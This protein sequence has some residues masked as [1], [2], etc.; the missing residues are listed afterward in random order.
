MGRRAGG[1]VESTAS[2]TAGSVTTALADLDAQL[3]ALQPRVEGLYLALARLTRALRREGPTDLPLGQLS[4]LATLVSSG[5]LRAADLAARES[6]AA[7]TLSRI[8][9]A[10]EAADLVERETNPNDARSVLVRPSAAGEA[11][12]RQVRESRTHRLAERLARLD[13]DQREAL[14]AAIPALLALTED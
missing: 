4:T 11:M 9:A 14:I 1:E 5:P 7:P 13:P 6:V 3:A 10:L 8:L 2:M 12:V